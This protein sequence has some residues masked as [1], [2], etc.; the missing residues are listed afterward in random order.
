MRARDALQMGYRLSSTPPFCFP[1]GGVQPR[2]RPTSCEHD[3]CRNEQT[4]L[5]QGASFNLQVILKMVYYN[6]F[7]MSAERKTLRAFALLFPQILNSWIL[8]RKTLN[9]LKHCKISPYLSHK[10]TIGY[11]GISSRGIY[12]LYILK[13]TTRYLLNVIAWRLLSFDPRQL[14]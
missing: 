7:E 8:S 5:E 13:V 10:Y 14:H 6:R 1:V 11:R 3:V 2:C 12:S 9:I 4:A